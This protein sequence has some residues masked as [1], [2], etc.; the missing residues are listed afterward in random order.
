MYL[1]Y[2][3]AFLPKNFFSPL[4]Y[5]KNEKKKKHLNEPTKLL[6]L[7]LVLILQIFVH[8]ILKEIKRRKKHDRA[9]R[10]ARSPHTHTPITHT[11]QVIVKVLLDI[12]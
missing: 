7:L 4:F 12:S 6:M 2:R 5:L 1:F 11:I 10:N 3:N 9:H 8:T